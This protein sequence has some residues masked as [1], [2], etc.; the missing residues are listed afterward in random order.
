MIIVFKNDATAE[1]LNSIER[2]LKRCNLKHTEIKGEKETIWGLV[3]DTAS[4]TLEEM[5]AF[6][7]V[8]KAMRV[9]EPYKLANRQ[10]SPEDLAID[11][12]GT[13]IGGGNFVVIG[14]PCAVET[15]EHIIEMGKI[16]KESGAHFLRGGAFKPRTSPYAFQGHGREGIMFMVEAREKTGLPIVTELMAC[17]QID[18]FEEYVDIIQIGARNMQNYDLLKEVGK[19]TKPVLL[20]RGMSATIKEWILA[21]EYILAGGNKNVIMCE[22]GIRTFETESRNTLDIGTIPIIKKYTNLPIIIDPSHAAGKYWMVESLSKAA[23]AAG[24]DGLTI[25]VHNL[26]QEALSD[27]AQSLKPAKFKRLMDKL[28]VIAPVV[29]KTIL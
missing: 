11:V 21:A 5:E 7:F 2:K 14:G 17:N 4:L 24:A 26:P 27:G 29:D 3:G 1:D 10:F 6:R 9:Q 12:A 25:E 19:S 8:K 28:K 22:R 18:I 13:K 20:K 16:V 23:L 15:K